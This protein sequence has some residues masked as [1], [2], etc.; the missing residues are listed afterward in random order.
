MAISSVQGEPWAKLFS[1]NDV[2][3]GETEWIQLRWKINTAGE[4]TVAR[5]GCV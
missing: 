3:K 2:E 5:T 1:L 4:K